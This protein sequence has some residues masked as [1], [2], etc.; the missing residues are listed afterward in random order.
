[1]MVY[2]KQR[3]THISLVRRDFAALHHLPVIFTL[4]RGL[5]ISL[6]TVHGFYRLPDCRGSAA[7][8]H[9]PV[10]FAP[11]WGCGSLYYPNIS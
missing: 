1:M 10:I 9:L 7:L 4:L 6:L 8:H 2:S 3:F 5:A 11:L